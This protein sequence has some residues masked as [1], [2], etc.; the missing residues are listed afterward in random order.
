MLQLHEF[1]QREVT[2]RRLA[3]GKCT[4]HPKYKFTATVAQKEDPGA[5]GKKAP[6]EPIADPRIKMRPLDPNQK[7]PLSA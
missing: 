5:H 4:N 7:E 6:P 3:E 2:A 1:S